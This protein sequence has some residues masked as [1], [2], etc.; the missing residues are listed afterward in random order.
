[1]PGFWAGGSRRAQQ[2]VR[3][4]F[5][6]ANALF[7]ARR[8]DRPIAWYA[9]CVVWTGPGLA[10]RGGRMLRDI[11]SGRSAGSV[12]WILVLAGAVASGGC[13]SMGLENPF[14]RRSAPAAEMVDDPGAPPTSAEAPPPGEP[15]LPLSPSQRFAD[16]PLP[17]GVKEDLDKTFVYEDRN[18]QIGRMVYT[19]R[20]GVNELAQFYIREC[21]AGGWALRNNIQAVGQELHFTKPGKRLTVFVRDLGPAKGRQLIL[22][23]TPDVS[24]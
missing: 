7:L 16:V 10:E 3:M 9:E 18:L 21:P 11:M 1:M 6:E 24:Q 22:T 17:Q 2:M 20:V 23:V 13:Q 12:Y 14:Q 8:F 19:T 15:G 5:R 4:A